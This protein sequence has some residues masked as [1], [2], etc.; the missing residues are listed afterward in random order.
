MSIT[1]NFT[2]SSIL[3]NTQIENA[4][5]SG[6]IDFVKFRKDYP[7]SKEVIYF[8]P[9][10]NPEIDENGDYIYYIIKGLRQFPGIAFS[11]KIELY[12]FLIYLDFFNL[13]TYYNTLFKPSLFFYINIDD[14]ITR[15]TPFYILRLLYR[16]Q[17]YKYDIRLFFLSL[18][19]YIEKRKFENGNIFIYIKKIPHS[20]IFENNPI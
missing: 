3:Y 1:E 19:K 8:P 2:R 13:T 11:S 16:D 7:N 5:I 9:G 12:F 14:N 17:L 20:E 10:D 15:E 4:D 18:I 6:L